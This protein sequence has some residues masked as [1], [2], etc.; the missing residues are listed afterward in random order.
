[1]D[2]TK[3]TL[4]VY[5]ICTKKAHVAVYLENR[6]LLHIVNVISLYV[7]P[8]VLVYII[9][10]MKTSVYLSLLVTLA[11][12]EK[13]ALQYFNSFLSLTKSFFIPVCRICFLFFHR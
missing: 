4:K 7:Y 12:K 1:M 3:E 9:K 2:R 11:G 8:F 6:K 10:E 5:E 13:E